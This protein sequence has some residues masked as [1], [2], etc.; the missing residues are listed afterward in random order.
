MANRQY[1]ERVLLVICH[2]SVGHHNSRASSPSRQSEPPRNALAS[3]ISEQSQ[4]NHPLQSTALR[5]KAKRGARGR[6][7][8]STFLIFPFSPYS[9]SFFPGFWLGRRR[10]V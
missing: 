7:A 3:S 2:I 8:L 5:A 10:N 1:A 4:A 6:P 9:L